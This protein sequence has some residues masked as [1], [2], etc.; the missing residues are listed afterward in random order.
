MKGGG[1]DN[2][3]IGIIRLPQIQVKKWIR[4]EG[5]SGAIGADR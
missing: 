4:E 3:L 1:P 2:P 5:Y